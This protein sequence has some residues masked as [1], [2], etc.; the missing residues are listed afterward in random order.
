MLASEIS[1]IDGIHNLGNY[2]ISYFKNNRLK[3][4]KIYEIKLFYNMLHLILV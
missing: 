2:Y 1:V 3:H 4:Y